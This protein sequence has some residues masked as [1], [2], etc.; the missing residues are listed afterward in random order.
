MDVKSIRD[1]VEGSGNLRLIKRLSRDR[2]AE[3]NW[4]SSASCISL[5]EY[6]ERVDEEDGKKKG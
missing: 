6:K 5:I 2:R 1:W 4:D 3:D